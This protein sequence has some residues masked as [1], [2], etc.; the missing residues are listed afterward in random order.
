MLDGTSSIGKEHERQQTIR[1]KNIDVLKKTLMELERQYILQV[2]VQIEEEE[3]AARS[4]VKKLSSACN[5][6]IIIM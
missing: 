5:K 4:E 6:I 2:N 3:E 1:S